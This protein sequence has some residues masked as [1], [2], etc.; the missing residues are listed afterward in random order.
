MSTFVKLVIHM[1]VYAVV[2]YA[3][4]D[5]FNL[6][7]G[8]ITGTVVNVDICVSSKLQCATLCVHQPT[9]VVF[10]YFGNNN[11]C[12]MLD[13]TATRQIITSNVLTYKVSSLFIYT[14]HLYIGTT[15]IKKYGYYSDFSGL[16]Y[17]LI[18]DCV[19]W[20][21]CIC[22]YIYTLCMLQCCSYDVRIYT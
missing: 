18:I 12:L 11:T 6:V 4:E 5:Y 15:I 10:Q 20:L 3:F 14:K 21:K 13:N 16:N 8:N 19:V 9:C 2:G 1:F 22:K 17:T 7:S